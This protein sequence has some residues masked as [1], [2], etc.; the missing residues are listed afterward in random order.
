VHINLNDGFGALNSLQNWCETPLKPENTKLY[1]A[2]ENEK[3]DESARLLK[4]VI[5]L[6][7]LSEAECKMPA[8]LQV[9]YKCDASESR[10]KYFAQFFSAIEAFAQ[11]YQDNVNGYGMFAVLTTDE[12]PL[13][14][15]R[16]AT[17]AD[18]NDDLNLAESYSED[19]PVIFNIILWFGVLIAFSMLAICYAIAYMDPGRDSII[20]RMTSTRIKKDN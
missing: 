1:K 10:D 3:N 18:L 17:D 7:V 15:S 13:K 9:D 20:Y 14:R 4:A 5:S 12:Q 2:L 6:L 11:K 8:F 19:Y 16:R